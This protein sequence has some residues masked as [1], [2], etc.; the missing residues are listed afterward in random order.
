[1]ESEIDLLNE[2]LKQIGSPLMIRSDIEGTLSVVD[3]SEVIHS[4]E[5][6]LWVLS[7]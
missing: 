4:M 7:L 2:A 3:T 1:M 5:E 6:V